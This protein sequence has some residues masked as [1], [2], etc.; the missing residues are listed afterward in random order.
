MIFPEGTRSKS[1]H[2]NEF[3]DKAFQPAIMAKASI[4]PV[5]LK[6]AYC[7]DAQY[8]SKE[9]EIYFDK[10]ISYEQYKDMTREEL[11]DFVKR[12]IQSH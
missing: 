5:C 4:V 1:D 12:Q 6:G 11:S 10:P 9:L 7:L 2:M 3:K 8:D